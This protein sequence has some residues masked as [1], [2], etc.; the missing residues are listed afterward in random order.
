VTYLPIL[1]LLFAV[2]Y[3]L[4]I[5]PQRRRQQE[6]RRTL[7]AIQPGVEVL[8]AGGL[9]GTV[10]D[11]GDDDVQVEIAPGTV[12]R[13][14]RRGIAGVVEPQ[15]AELDELDRAQEEAEQEVVTTGKTD[16]R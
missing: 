7:D 10:R 11:V 2:M 9:Y 13:V 12:V 15:D 14:A 6:A 5:R 1:I 16:E 8:T 3:M 4:I